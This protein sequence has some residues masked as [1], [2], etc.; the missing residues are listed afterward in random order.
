VFKKII[1]ALATFAFIAVA[2]MIY[3][4][5]DDTIGPEKQQQ[6]RVAPRRK[7]TR[8]TSTTQPVGVSRLKSKALSFK[9]ANIPPGRQPKISIFDNK[10]NERIR[11]LSTEWKPVSDNEFHMVQ[12]TARILLPGGQVAYIRADEGQVI[13][14]RGDSD[15]YNPKSGWLRGYV[16]IFVDRTTPE[17]RALHPDLSEPDQ[18]AESVVKIFMEEVHFD[19]EMASLNSSGP[20]ILQSPDGTIEGKGLWLVWNEVSRRIKKLRI[21]EGKRAVIRSTAL[22]GFDLTGDVEVV[23]TP[24]QDRSADTQPAIAGTDRTSA[25]SAEEPADEKEEEA[26]ALTL[27]DPGEEIGKPKE[28]R[29]D[30]YQIVFND[31]VEARQLEGVAVKGRLK[32]DMLKLIRDFSRTERSAIEH[33][34]DDEA[35]KTSKEAATTTAPAGEKKLTGPQSSIELVWSGEMVITPAEPEE[36]QQ[37]LTG[38]RFHIIAT[39]SPVEIVDSKAGSLI[40][41]ELEYHDEAKKIWL[42]RGAADHPVVMKEGPDSQLTGREIF[43]DRKA[44]VARVNGAGKMTSPATDLRGQW[45]NEYISQDPDLAEKDS[46]GKIEASWSKSAELHFDVIKSKSPASRPADQGLSSLLPAG[47]YIKRAVLDGEASFNMPKGYFAANRIEADFLEPVSTGP[48]DELGTF[49]DTIHAAGRVR[50]KEG[51]TEIECDRLDVQMAVDEMGNNFPDIARAYGNIT[52]HNEGRRGKVESPNKRTETVRARD[53]LTVYLASV[54][55]P[56]T[57]EEKA[58]YIAAA[59]KKKIERG[60]DKWLKFEQKLLNRRRLELTRMVARGEVRVRSVDK[61]FFGTRE[62]FDL[63]ADTLDCSFTQDNLIKQSLVV[64]REDQ[65]AKVAVDDFYIQGSQISLDM[66]AESV[67]VPGAG[68]LRFYTEEDLDG[69]QMDDPVPVTITWKRH[70][71]LRGRDNTGTFI[72]NVLAE[73]DNNVLEC[74]QLRIRFKDLPKQRAEASA[75]TAGDTDAGGSMLDWFRPDKDTSTA[76]RFT[77]RIRK[78]PTFLHAVGNAKILSSDFATSGGA[79]SR[80][81]NWVL[82]QAVTGSATRPASAGEQRL[83]SRILIKGPKFAIDLDNEYMMV[84]GKGQLL[85]E[86]YRMPKRRR[87]SSSDGSAILNRSTLADIQNSGLSQTQFRWQNSMSFLNNR[88][89]AVFDHEVVMVHL[90]GEH[91]VL[92]KELKAALGVDITKLAG[93]K[94]RNAD[95]TCDNLLVEYKPDEEHKNRG[96]S[97][98]SRAV[99]LKAFSATGSVRIRDNNRSAQCNLATYTDDTDIVRISGSPQQPAQIIDSDPETGAMKIGWQGQ[100]L[101]WNLETGAIKATESRILAPR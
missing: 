100:V 34:S 8:I 86:D 24:G 29:I 51:L 4:W 90:A 71:F 6:V 67:E 73:S 23:D 83:L 19:L 52:V 17:W 30:T 92:T 16:R 5:Q 7:A 80:A 61:T 15:N 97:L 47:T 45:L 50:M 46:P 88:N 48:D 76:G 85:I 31:D 77:R 87:A 40:C 12:P 49:A 89:M 2:Y 72:G 9:D 65:P 39:G 37:E 42:R 81:L 95:L 43:L 59:E 13:V 57:D 26:E 78:Q 38:D 91:M 1:L 22:A 69:R 99:D 54:P 64:G 20:I 68:L 70:L 101:N 53:E 96:P 28:D 44:R 3:R 82:P 14:Q 10:G 94:N 62:R 21:A 25:R 75:S 27:I 79:V 56:V 98:L 35:A 58:R 60:S 32:A 18:H 84:E 63:A 36:G 11:F 55:R 74:D 66:T 33:I 41:G 93:A